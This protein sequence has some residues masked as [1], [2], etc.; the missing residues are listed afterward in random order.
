METMAPPPP[1]EVAPIVPPAPTEAPVLLNRDQKIAMSVE[2]SLKGNG[3]DAVTDDAINE[4]TV[5]AQDW[6]DKAKTE[7]I[8]AGGDHTIDAP[9]INTTPENLPASINVDPGKVATK[10]LFRRALSRTGRGVKKAATRGPAAIVDNTVAGVKNLKE[11]PG[12]AKD[13]IQLG[14]DKRFMKKADRFGLEVNPDKQVKLGYKERTFTSGD[15]V[16]ETRKAATDRMK[17]RLH[18]MTGKPAKLAYRVADKISAKAFDA[19]VNASNRATARNDKA[20]NRQ[21]TSAAAKI[22]TGGHQQYSV[23]SKNVPY[24]YGTFFMMFSVLDLALA[25]YTFKRNLE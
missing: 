2:W 21:A 10:G 14:R 23:R 9:E 6:F 1:M 19:H 15:A 18:K 17:A 24:I 11:A 12:L 20:Q 8:I 4:R 3:K 16:H 5:E 7:D 25:G 22:S 13:A